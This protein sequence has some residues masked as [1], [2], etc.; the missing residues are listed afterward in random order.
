MRFTALCF[1][2]LLAFGLKHIGGQQTH[3]TEPVLLRVIPSDLTVRGLKPCTVPGAVTMIARAVNGLSGVEYLPEPCLWE[4][5]YT[6]EMAPVSLQGRT[7]REALDILVGLDS[8]YNWTETEGV[9][10]TR[11]SSAWTDRY[12]F[13]NG[14]VGNF[15][16]ENSNVHGAIAALQALLSPPK[17]PLTPPEPRTDEGAKTFSVNAENVTVLQLLNSLVRAHGRMYWQVTYCKDQA[18]AENAQIQLANSPESG[19]SAI[20][21]SCRQSGHALAPAAL[22]P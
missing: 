15:R 13:V 3:D 6:V 1:G 12:N 2:C 20:H 10:V 7:V 5:P 16:L 18:R 4:K 22:A 9:I 21:P 17:G 14:N 8:R 19:G 11:P